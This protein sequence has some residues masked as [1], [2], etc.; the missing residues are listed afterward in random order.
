MRFLQHVINLDIGQFT[1]HISLFSNTNIYL[2]TV[3]LRNKLMLILFNVDTRF[4]FKFSAFTHKAMVV[5][6]GIESLKRRKENEDAPG[7][8]YA[9]LNPVYEEQIHSGCA[10]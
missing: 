6:D 10:F 3:S 9:N 7:F 8:T 5:G 2:K 1:L 4:S